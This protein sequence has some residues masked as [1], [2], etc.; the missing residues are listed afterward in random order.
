[1]QWRNIL[2]SVNFCFL[3]KN[4]EKLN[5]SHLNQLVSFYKDDELISAKDI[6]LR[7][8]R[9][10][11]DEI[12]IDLDL[13]RMPNRQGISKSKH[14]A[15]D[16]F[17]LLTI[18]DERKLWDAMSRFVAEDLERVPF[19]NADYMNVIHMARKLETFE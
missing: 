1:M 2:L 16:I 12:G 7:E 15:D 8:V 3:R 9:H 5:E 13:P 17:K 18:V 14:T 4:Y 19:I 6:L 11:A 10:A